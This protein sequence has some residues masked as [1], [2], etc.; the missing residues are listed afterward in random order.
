MAVNN[1]RKLKA[2]EVDPNDFEAKKKLMPEPSDGFKEWLQNTRE[3]T[4]E[5]K[6]YHNE[7]VNDFK[8]EDKQHPIDQMIRNGSFDTEGSYR[9]TRRMFEENFPDSETERRRKAKEDEPHHPMDILFR[10][11]LNVSDNGKDLDHYGTW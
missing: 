8:Q 4:E 1:I 10:G 9:R 11:K 6:R 7:R 3:R 2:V 5:N